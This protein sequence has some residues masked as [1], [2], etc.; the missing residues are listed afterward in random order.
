[1]NF[2]KGL[3]GGGGGGGG[4]E[5]IEYFLVRIEAPEFMSIFSNADEEK[6]IKVD[7]STLKSEG[8]PSTVNGLSNELDGSSG[9]CNSGYS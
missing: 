9:S 7:G 5:F 1:M 2:L 6:S 4:F 3:L 8:F